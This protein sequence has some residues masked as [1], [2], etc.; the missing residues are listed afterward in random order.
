MVRSYAK[1]IISGAI[2]RGEVISDDSA[3]PGGHQTRVSGKPKTGVG[4][5]VFAWY[6]KNREK[7]FEEK[8]GENTYHSPEY[9]NWICSKGHIYTNGVFPAGEER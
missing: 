6:L 1:N 4:A 8:K 7:K 2:M 5:F 9:D 3:G